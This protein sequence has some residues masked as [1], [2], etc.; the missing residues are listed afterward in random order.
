M[1]PE[2]EGYQLA[3]AALQA[4]QFVPRL[5]QIGLRGAKLAG[6]SDFSGVWWGWRSRP[7]TWMLHRWRVTRCISS[8]ISRL[9]S[10]VQLHRG[11]RALAQSGDCPLDAVRRVLLSR[12]QPARVLPGSLYPQ[13]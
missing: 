11:Y 6:R 5:F 1:A 2:R 7:S 10:S 3:P 13:Q 12:F 8:E 4:L 9:P